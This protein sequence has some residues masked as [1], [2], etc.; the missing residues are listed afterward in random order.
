MNTIKISFLVLLFSGSLLAQSGGGHGENRER[1][2]AMRVGYLTEQMNLT[3]EEAQVFWPVYNTYRD[4]LKKVM[5]PEGK[6]Q[7]PAHHISDEEL[8]KMNDEEVRQMLMAEMKKQKEMVNLHE[9]YFLEFTKVIPVK[10]VAL[11]Y[12]AEREFQR[13]LMRKISA[14][15]TEKRD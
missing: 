6:K 14:H 2:E 8:S 13:K 4:E 15:S 12:K 11:L 9:K 5:H 10:K 3:P 1:I 7:R